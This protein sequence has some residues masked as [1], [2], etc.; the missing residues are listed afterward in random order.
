[1]KRVLVAG[2]FLLAG[3]LS[4]P[5]MAA[6]MP[7]KA[8]EGPVPMWGW[9]EFYFGLNI[10]WAS[11]TTSWCTEAEGTAC[12]GP[13]NFSSGRPV[14]VVEGGQFGMRWQMPN[15]PLVLGVEA[16]YD[17]L[18]ISTSAAGALAP[19]TQARS[20]EFNNLSS[21]TGS[22]G[23][24]M[25]RLLAYGKGGWAITELHPDAI[26]GVTGADLSTWQWVNGWTAGAG[27]EYMLFTHFS[28]G[29]EYNYYQFDVS[30]MSAGPNS[31]GANIA[32]PF[33]DFG[34]TSI[35]TVSGRINIKL[36]PYGP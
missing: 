7:V 33:C 27:L 17:G 11:P 3:A 1:M 22:V 2:I 16:M 29:L 6:D 36:W 23:L 21:A 10:G 18:D 8:P 24:A 34:K 31:L 14:G 28:I 9:T 4:S 5:L 32:C 30:N 25:G 15:S 35:Q 26:D 13:D 19:T 12:P 20:I